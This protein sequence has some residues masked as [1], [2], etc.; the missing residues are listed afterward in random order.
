MMNKILIFGSA[1]QSH[2]VGRH[3]E[4]ARKLTTVDFVWEV[5]S[6]QTPPERSNRVSDV[7]CVIPVIDRQMLHSSAMDGLLWSLVRETACRSDFCVI[8]WLD[9]ITCAELEAAAVESRVAAYIVD[10][11]QIT[12]EMESVQELIA[13]VINHLNA[14]ESLRA[15]DRWD[16]VT[17]Y[18]ADDLGKGARA[19][20][21]LLLAAAL[22]ASASILHI[23][24]IT[25]LETKPEDHDIL[26]IFSVMALTISAIWHL[27]LR[28]LMLA[29]KD[30]AARWPRSIISYQL[31]GMCAFFL[32]YSLFKTA[33]VTPRGAMVRLTSDALA[34]VL[35]GFTFESLVRVGR[36]ARYSNLLFDLIPFY[37]SHPAKGRDVLGLLYDNIARFSALP[38]R[39][40]LEPPHK[41]AFI[42]YSRSSL[43]CRDTASRV[44]DY[45]RGQGVHIFLDRVSM[46]PG[47]SWKRQIRHAIEDSNVFIIVLDG[48]AYQRNWIIAEFATAYNR[49]IETGTPELFVIHSDGLTFNGADV[50]PVARL[51]SELAVQP[52]VR[53]PQRMRFR[54]SAVRGDNLK[55]ICT[56]IR[57]FRIS[58]AAGPILN[59]LFMSSLTHTAGFF[60][61]IAYL[62]MFLNIFIPLDM[63]GSF[64]LSRWSRIGNGVREPLVLFCALEIGVCI[65]LAVSSFSKADRLDKSMKFQ[66]Y[67]E[68][69][70]GSGFA[71]VVAS[72]LGS[73]SLIGKCLM[74]VGFYLGMVV[75]NMYVVLMR[76]YRSTSWSDDELAKIG[77]GVR[78][79]AG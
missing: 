56:A 17:R 64:D 39:R 44:S 45:L 61:L 52:S 16:K 1:R 7:V 55:E 62:G 8:P 24:P 32:C 66:G 67:Y 13:S 12:S 28:T 49:K 10:N 22:F 46:T 74:P 54:L 26:V 53:I 31:T 63:F 43:W 78:K 18:I 6:L 60:V 71:V 21:F 69:A 35:L 23:L 37:L 14:L 29:G 19:F 59:K 41:R 75:A 5:E 25:I 4:H 57:W 48:S 30:L 40:F 38:G 65:R 33:L 50:S 68:L 70:S 9:G 51:F 73:L 11:I 27:D 15:T 36:R 2:E 79:A 42:S 76:T 72:W 3:L 34:G 77:R 20:E 58:G 47:Q